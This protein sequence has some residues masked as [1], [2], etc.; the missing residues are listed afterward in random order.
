MYKAINKTKAIQRYVEAVSL[1]TGARAL[2]WEENKSCMSI[3]VA[4][5]VTPRVKH[6]EI[7]VCLIQEQF[8]N[9]I[10]V[11]KYE[12]SSVMPEDMCTKPCSG[13]IIS[14]SI[15]WMTGFRLYPPIDTENYQL[16]ILYEFIVKCTHCGMFISVLCTLEL[17]SRTYDMISCNT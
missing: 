10:F 15:K 4:K 17:L 3:F 1:H 16:I 9:D 11:L 13:P 12:N 14:W 2:Y 5:I 8:D 7:H 6:I